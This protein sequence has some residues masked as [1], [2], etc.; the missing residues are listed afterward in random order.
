MKQ[1]EGKAW[2]AFTTGEDADTTYKIN[3]ENHTQDSYAVYAILRDEFGESIGKNIVCS[4]GKTATTDFTKL[5]PNTP[6]FIQLLSKENFKED[7][8]VEYSI[9]IETS[10]DKSA[11]SMMRKRR[12]KFRLKSMKRKFSL[13]RMKLHL[14]M[15]QQL[16]RF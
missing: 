15:K 13:L 2:F 6:Y 8:K 10:E 4:G 9:S 12:L 3:L 14:L 5:K 11:L 16:K 7:E 1:E